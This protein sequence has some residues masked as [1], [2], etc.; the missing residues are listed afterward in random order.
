MCSSVCTVLSLDIVEMKL[1][2][3]AVNEMT[4]P[5]YV[6]VEKAVNTQNNLGLED[7]TPHTS[8]PICRG[9]GG[10]WWRNY[11]Q[12]CLKRIMYA[13]KCVQKKETISTI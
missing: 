5:E 12:N 10:C 13:T 9:T 6:L 2:E 4:F 3:K 8:T 1:V 11:V 7:Q